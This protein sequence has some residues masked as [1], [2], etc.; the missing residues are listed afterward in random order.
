MEMEQNEV[1]PIDGPSTRLSSKQIGG[2]LVAGG[3]IWGLFLGLR[4]HTRLR[5]WL[6][7]IGLVFA[8]IAFLSEERRARIGAAVGHIL[9]EMDGLD[10]VA[11][12]QV[13]IAVARETVK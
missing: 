11:K 12:V 7:P 6:L 10:P 5:N 1:G 9:A 8:G 4:R 13:L 3:S 2:L